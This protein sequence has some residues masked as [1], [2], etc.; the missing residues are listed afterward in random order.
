LSHM[1]NAAKRRGRGDGEVVSVYMK[2]VDAA[3]LRARAESQD[4]SVS[5]EVRR[6]LRPYLDDTR[7]AGEP[8]AGHKSASRGRHEATG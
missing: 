8:G 6:A 1:P 4:R 7:P 3:L 2:P 5:A